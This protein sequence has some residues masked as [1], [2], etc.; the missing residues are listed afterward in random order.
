MIKQKCFEATSTID[1]FVKCSKSEVFKDYVYPSAS[2]ASSDVANLT[3]KR[4]HK[5]MYANP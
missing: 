4:T 3:E 5:P 1:F 2:L